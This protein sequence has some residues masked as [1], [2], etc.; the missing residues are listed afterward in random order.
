M[1][2]ETLRNIISDSIT[3]KLTQMVEELSTSGFV[4]EIIDKYET[5]TGVILDS[6]DVHDM[7]GDKVLPLYTKLSEYI[8]EHTL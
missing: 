3:E 1:N 8:V 6:E 5:E 2:K 4:D 7:I